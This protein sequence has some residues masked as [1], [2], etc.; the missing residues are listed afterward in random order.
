MIHRKPCFQQKLAAIGF[1]YIKIVARLKHSRTDNFEM[2]S[3]KISEKSEREV[4]QFGGLY[5]N[6]N[7]W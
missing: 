5:H 7:Y 1:L 3:I 6:R 4:C 2:I